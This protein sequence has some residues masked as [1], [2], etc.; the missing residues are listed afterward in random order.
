MKASRLGLAKE[1][2]ASVLPIVEARSSDSGAF[3]SVLELLIRTGRSLPEAMMMMIPEAW[4]N[5]TL[6]PRDRRDFYEYHSA[7]MEPWDGPALVAFTDG[8]FLGA[9]LDR[10]GLRPGRFAITKSGKV[11]MAS[12]VGVVDIEP[13]D[14]LRKGRLMPGNIFLVDFEAGR[15]I[16]D[17][18]MKAT[19]SR[20]H[21]YGDWLARQVVRLPEVRPARP[22]RLL[23]PITPTH[24]HTPAERAT[25]NP[26]LL[27]PPSPSARN[28]GLLAAARRAVVRWRRAA[29]VGRARH[30][31]L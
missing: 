5:D 10:N 15:V 18:E 30:Q 12:E 21:S 16:D 29:A 8:R 24:K 25:W 11:V 6:I 3:D 22:H 1:E 26:N 19:I 9:T 2:L 28:A 20:S 7:L 27:S 23:P 31:G 13:N 4:Q 14:V 17:A